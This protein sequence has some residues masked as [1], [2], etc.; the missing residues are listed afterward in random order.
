MPR[1]F[2]LG[3]SPA[4][5]AKN[6]A[7]CAVSGI[8]SFLFIA[9]INSLVLELIGN[10]IQYRNES[11][12]LLGFILLLFIWSRRVLSVQIIDYSQRLFWQMRLSI[13]QMTLLA[14]YEQFKIHRNKI[15]ASL[16]R[17]VSVMTQA[18]VNLIQFSSAVV[19]I[20]A[21][22]FYIW[23][24]SLVLCC[25]T[26][27]V[28]VVGI[29]VY[30]I[31]V[32]INHKYL[33]KARNL[34]DE[35][36]KNFNSILSGFKELYLDSRKGQ[37]IFEKNIKSISNDSISFNTRAFLGLLNNQITGQLLFYV[38]IGTTLMIFVDLLNLQ[39]MLVVNFLFILLFLLGSV[40]TVM[41][42]LPGL[43]QAKVSSN[44]IDELRSS[45]ANHQ[46][47]NPLSYG[48]DQLREFEKIKIVD[49]EFSYTLESEKNNHVRKFEIGPLSMDIAKGDVNF[50]FGGNGSGKTTFISSFLGLLTPKN[51]QIFFNNELLDSTNYVQ[52][53]MLF[54]VVFSDFYLFDGIYG[55]ESF[56]LDKAN[57][58]LELFEL[59]GIVSFHNKRFST[60]DLSTGQRKRLALISILLEKKPVLVLD[61]WAADQDPYFRKKFY[62]EII[63]ILSKEGFTIIAITH[64]DKYFDC[65]N[66]LYQMD[67]GKMKLIK[68]NKN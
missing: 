52:Y 24:L 41:V 34:E 25:I 57:Y 13:I 18:S 7:L 33:V 4:Q 16:V 61:E 8:F 29:I 50:I 9:F 49:L 43:I 67:Y 1:L 38:L 66:K 19:M 11:F 3:T 28:V 62:T 35:F 63:P 54:G 36:I 44:N 58:Y 65:A 30:Q 20:I 26:L 21:C 51:G 37:E 14:H 31:G 12:I 47:S 48:S 2:F 10:G 64:D 56:E 17:D 60:I 45:L 15:H 59:T 55:I 6:I 68:T 40:E 53:R 46:I 32:I 23:N 39:T 42:L 5:Y 22:F 27:G